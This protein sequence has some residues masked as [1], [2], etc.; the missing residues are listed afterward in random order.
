MEADFS[1]YATKNDLLCSDGVTIR[2][3][4]FRHHDGEKVPLV[5][6]HQ[7][8]SPT[9]VLG[10]AVLE[11]RDD[12]VY[13]YAYFNDTEV[14]R[15]AKTMV[16]HGDVKSLSIHAGRL[17]KK[18]ADVIHGV[19]REVSLVLAGAN[20][21][22]YIDNVYIRH[23][24]TEI[25]SEEEVII[26]SGLGLEHADNSEKETEKVPDTTTKSSNA[27]SDD[28]TVK[29]VFDTLNEEQKNVVYFLI[30][31][32]VN[33]AAGNDDDDE[34]KQ[35]DDDDDYIS[36]DGMEG[37]E[38]TRN[39]FDQSSGDNAKNTLSHAQ[40]EAITADAKKIGSLKESV[41]AHA[42]EYG[43]EDI[44]ILFPDAKAIM[45]S[46]EIVS[47]RTEWVK[48][49]LDG[50]KHSPF[51]R[52]KT[53]AADITAQEARARGYVKGNLKKEEIIKL[54]ARKTD[55]TTIYKKQKL[56]RDDI[57]DITDLDIVA[58]LKA[59]MR[60]MLDEEI[61]RAVLVGDGRSE[62]SEDKIDE[63][64]IRPIAKDVDFYAH[65]V[66]LGGSETVDETIEALIRARSNFRGSNTPTVFATLPFITDMLLTKD[67]MGRRIYESME[68]LASAL[69]ARKLVPVEVMEE[70]EDLVAIIVSLSDYTIGANKG[71]NVSMFDDF[72]IDYNQYKYLMETRIS[73][74]LTKP[75][76]AV[77]VK[78]ASGTEV[79]PAAPSFNGSTNEITFP[80]NA[81]GVEYTIDGLVVTGKTT[82][83]EDTDVVARPAE[84]YRFP[85]DATRNWTY[86]YTSSATF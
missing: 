83:T 5:W 73:G 72:D 50:V 48:E 51:A 63:D 11:N 15:H 60:L 10:H 16:E 9:N 80:P 22:A 78:R 21:G 34:V 62:A 81:T 30:G 6:Q 70:D 67:K 49:V 44:D 42:A 77:I 46:P 12:G 47:R 3:G 59:E 4:A 35:S 61:A 38:M 84:G 86:V 1:G 40:V 66:I 79:S 58:W 56:D 43:F 13:T 7:S 31:E 45:N 57:V 2:A 20:P 23:G 54:L 36:H 25:M 85:A 71:G 76:S 82:I 69:M 41:L 52:I 75:K 68:S 74:A 17:R 26:Y 19:I 18:G 24:D 65:E 53:V 33:D 64:K 29:D 8:D 55:P 28:K 32:A 27:S 37:S 14:A 39:V